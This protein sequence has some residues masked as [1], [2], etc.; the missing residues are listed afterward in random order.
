MTTY[1]GVAVRGNYN[2]DLTGREDADHSGGIHSNPVLVLHRRGDNPT[3]VFAP[4]VGHAATVVRVPLSGFVYHFSGT[5][6]VA[7]RHLAHGVPAVDFARFYNS[8]WVARHVIVYRAYR[9]SD[10]LTLVGIVKEQTLDLLEAPLANVRL[11]FKST[12]LDNTYGATK[13]DDNGGYIIFLDAGETD[14]EISGFRPESC[15]VYETVRLDEHPASTDIVMRV[16][17]AC[18]ISEE[19]TLGEAVDEV[20]NREI[21]HHNYEPVKTAAVITPSGAYSAKNTGGVPVDIAVGATADVINVTLDGAVAIDSV[22]VS[23]DGD[24]EFRFLINGIEVVPRKRTTKFDDD[25]ELVGGTLYANAGSV[26]RVVCINASSGTPAGSIKAQA[27]V[28]GR[29]L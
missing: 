9:S 18:V 21:G 5:D 8:T 25:G 3:N 14:Y 1:V 27:T 20:L 10:K 29:N 4:S 16:P 15:K 24:A 26:L 13:S 11:W 2:A 28:A 23:A 6:I 22:R 12:S 19:I 7:V 17:L